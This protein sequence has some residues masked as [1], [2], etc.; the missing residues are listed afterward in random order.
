MSDESLKMPKMDMKDID[1]GNA[2][3]Q[4]LGV[5]KLDKTVIGKVAQNEKGGTVAALFLLIGVIAGP[6]AQLAFGIRV[7][8]VVVRPDITATITG[9]LVA[10][11]SA[12][13]TI[14]VTT[15]VATKLFKGAGSFAAYF[16]VIGLAYGLNVL[17]IVVSLVPGFGVFIA[18]IVGIWM[19]AI[20]FTTIKSVFHLDDTNAVLTIVV[21]I[22]AFF[23][24]GAAVASLGLGVATTQM[25]TL[26]LSDLSISY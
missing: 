8:N 12:L 19:L 5:I 26:D 25:N 20:A 18:L 4:F 24:L 10:L 13:L 1:V 14:L 15:L 6:L 22:V 2:F 7:F 16:R 3:Q 23:L 9:S 21:T 17:N 11:V